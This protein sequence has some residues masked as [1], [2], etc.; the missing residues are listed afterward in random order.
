MSETTGP[1]IVEPAHALGP[2]A[3]T[4]WTITAALM[5][6]PVVIALI[7]WGAVLAATVTDPYWSPVV[8]TA[9]AVAVAASAHVVVV[10]RWRYRVHRWEVSTTAV[11]TRSG[12]FVQERRIAPLSRV[13]TV[14]TERGP[15]D[16]AL[17]L[18]TVTVTTA[19]SAGAVK[20]AALDLATAERTAA[21]IT[22]AAAR[23]RSDAT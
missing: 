10:P 11:H 1:T 7:V 13:Q 21:A 9:L 5:W 6:I 20:I 3:K 16:R 15:L 14:D 2:R 19:S 23:S 4:L 18:A 17:G 8:I 22:E 12:W